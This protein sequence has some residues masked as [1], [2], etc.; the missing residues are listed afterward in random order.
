MSQN[1]RSGKRDLLYSAWHRARSIRRWLTPRDAHSCGVIDI[2]W[3]EFCV[4]CSQPLALIETQRSSNQ[5]KPAK[6][7][8]AL[9]QLA[10]LEAFS[11]SYVP[12]QGKLHDGEDIASF[13]VR[14]LWPLGSIEVAE[15]EPGEYASWLCA[16]RLG[17]ECAAPKNPPATRRAA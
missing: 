2:D 5:P 4:F 9:A 1:E 11:V 13:R 12:T 16:L 8:V 7:T 14:Q 3:C 6:V 10:G 17:H 15:L